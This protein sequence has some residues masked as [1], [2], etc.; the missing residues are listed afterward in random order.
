MTYPITCVWEITM[1]CNMRCKHCGSVCKNALPGELSTEEALKF[2]DSCADMGMVWISISGGEP[3]TRK[4]LVQIVKYAVEKGVGINIITNGWL[5]NEE[6]AKQLGDI[7][8]GV[9]VMIS[10]E[11]PEYIHDFIRK[12]GSFQRSKKSFEILK[13]YEIE[14]GCITTLTKQ[15][16]AHLDE[17]KYFLIQNGIG[18]WQVQ[19][20]LPM[21]SLGKHA[22]WVLDPE[23]VPDIIDYC[24]KVSNEGKIDIFPA[25][26]IGYY[27]D[28]Q[29]QIYKNSYHCDNIPTWNGCAAGIYS[30]GILHN[31]DIIGCTS[32]RDKEYIEGN[33]KDKSLKEIWENPNSFSWRR[34]FT[35]ENLT[36]DCKK[37]SYAEKCLGGCPNTRKCMNGTIN[38]ENLYCTQNLILKE[39][40]TKSIL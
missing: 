21:G 29:D 30:F 11:G 37:C 34:K 36:G 15:N 3:F 27:N 18:L 38:S 26:C 17:L 40:F 22:D 10:L 20:G 19:L 9:R 35:K 25:D 33:I 6:I 1:A 16:L 28:K 23:Q 31:G 7:G 24:Y 8:G 2:V 39:K 4:D 13:K 12:K 32:I 5:I 14:S